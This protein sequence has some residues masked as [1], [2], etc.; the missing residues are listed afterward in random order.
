MIIHSKTHGEFVVTLDEDCID[1]VKALGKWGVRNN[2]E[3]GHFYVEKRVNGNLIALHRFLTKAPPGTYVDHINGNT[4]DNRMVNLRICTNSAN[5]RNAKIRKG[6]TSG[7][8]G[9]SWEPRTSSWVAQ[10]KVKYKRVWLGRHKTLQDAQKARKE[11]ETKY[12]DI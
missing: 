8:R 9:V 2:G 4:L 3:R 11:A 1:K 6:N 5:L 12:W 10:I 7:I